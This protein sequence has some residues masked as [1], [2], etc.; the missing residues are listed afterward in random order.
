ME[1]T[2]VISSTRCRPSIFSLQA[3]R[4]RCSCWNSCS[5]YYKQN[6]MC[7]CYH[8]MFI[9]DM[10]NLRGLY[11]TFFPSLFLLWFCS[12]CGLIHST[13]YSSKWWCIV[14][15][16]HVADSLSFCSLIYRKPLIIYSDNCKFH[17]SYWWCPLV[18][19][20]NESSFWQASRVALSWKDVNVVFCFSSC[21]NRARRIIM[22]NAYMCPLLNFET[23]M[24]WWTQ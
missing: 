18:N 21:A 17:K 15:P 12:F 19:C 8:I 10:R 20:I 3:I 1:I 14:I 11:S 13:D 4:I 6:Y 22:Q 7:L 23:R 24:L 5:T 2:N 16:D 9:I